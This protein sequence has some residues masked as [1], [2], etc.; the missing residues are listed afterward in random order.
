MQEQETAPE[1]QVPVRDD[2][3]E[4]ASEQQEQVV[5]EDK[6]HKRGIVSENER[7]QRRDICKSIFR[8]LLR[9]DLNA[10]QLDEVHQ[11]VVTELTGN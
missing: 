5:A 6:A 9:S 3:E 1:V 8:H 2:S 4:Q 7:R 10:E 11:R